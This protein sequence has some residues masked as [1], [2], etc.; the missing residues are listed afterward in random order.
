MPPYHR[1]RSGQGREDPVFN[2]NDLLPRWIR[3]SLAATD[4]YNVYT[5]IA[6]AAVVGLPDEDVHTR[7][8]QRKLPTLANLVLGTKLHF[9]ADKNIATTISAFE[10]IQYVPFL[11]ALQQFLQLTCIGIVLVTGNLE[12]VE[13][14]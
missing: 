1:V 4:S 10:A 13:L 9:D 12:A 5:R 11:E 2:V 6:N 14:I 3:S 7:N 8:F